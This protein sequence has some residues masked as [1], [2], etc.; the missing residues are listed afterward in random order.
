MKAWRTLLFCY[1]LQLDDGSEYGNKYL[2][3]Y[4]VIIFHNAVEAGC[5][6]LESVR[7]KDNGQPASLGNTSWQIE[8]AR[9]R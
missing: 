4:L 8:V 7:W 3:T 5:V 9:T 2:S 6:A 1:E